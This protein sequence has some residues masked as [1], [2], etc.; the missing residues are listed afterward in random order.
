ML[1]RSPAFLLC[2]LCS[3]SLT[4]CFKL[5]VLTCAPGVRSRSVWDTWHE[6]RVSRT[7]KSGILQ[8]DSQRPREGIAE[9]FKL[10]TCCIKLVCVIFHHKRAEN[11]KTT[12]AMEDS[13]TIICRFSVYLHL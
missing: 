12:S 4:E 6:L 11:L 2:V 8:V 13:H 3:Y 9:V 1:D 7:A 5:N 10:Y